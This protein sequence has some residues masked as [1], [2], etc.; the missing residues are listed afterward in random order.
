M[1]KYRN[2]LPQSDG[3]MFL[4][5]GGMETCLIFHDNWDLPHFASFTLLNQEKGVAALT[6]YFSR[7]AEIAR[8]DGAGFIFESA[9]WRASPDWGDLLGYDRAAL[10]AANR[11][12]VEIFLPLREQFETEA[13][14]MVISGCLGPRGDGYVAGEAMTAE[15]AEAYHAFQVG[16]FAETEADMIGAFTMTNAPEAIGITRAAQAKGMPVAISF[17][18]ETDGR[19]PTGQSLPDAIAEV[20]AA[21]GKGPAYYMIN[22]AHPDHFTGVLEGPWTSRI[23]GLQANASRM[24][25]AEL[26][27]ASEL[28]DGDPIELGGQYV[29]LLRAQPQINVVGGCCGTDH[30]HIQAI[31]AACRKAA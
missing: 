10:A 28:D 27:E 31:S 1:P 6:S 18:L 22:C 14:P 24:S 2:N 16:V 21:T 20:D 13:S 5:D 7:H 15:E 26:D 19:L 11:K 23:G 9:T 8:N 3:S 25:H 30:R 17:T 4:T 12:A 29:E